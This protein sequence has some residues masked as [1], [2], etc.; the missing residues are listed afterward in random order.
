VKGVDL[1]PQGLPRPPRTSGLRI[2]VAASVL[3]FALVTVLIYV[4]KA[5]EIAGLS[6]SLKT[7]QEDYARYAWLDRSTDETRKRR[8]EALARL[9]AAQ[10]QIGAGLPAQEILEVLPRVI[11]QGVR[12]QQLALGSDGKA[13]V[14]GEAVSLEAVAS[15][16]LALRDAGLFADGWLARTSRAGEGESAGAFVFEVHA[17]LSGAGGGGEQP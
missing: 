13:V 10:R 2:L 7:Q 8:D 14:N 5:Q 9:S 11:P 16:A 3:G 12:L 6:R 4:A 17:T 1:L 15:L